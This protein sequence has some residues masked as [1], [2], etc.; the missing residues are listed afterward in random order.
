ML[1]RDDAVNKP[2][3]V[4]ALSL[5]NGV[6]A[7]WHGK[8][9]IITSPILDAETLL[10]IVIG[11]QAV[12]TSDDALQ[13]L[14]ASIGA[15]NNG[16]GVW[17]LMSLAERIECVSAAMNKILKGDKRSELITCLQ[18]EICKNAADAAAEVDRT[19]QFVQDVIEKLRCSSQN[20]DGDGGG[21]GDDEEGRSS[22]G[23][24]DVAGTRYKTFRSPVG[25]VL[26]LGP[27]NYPLNET[28]TALIPALLLGNVCVLKV[29]ALG[30]LV[31]AL[32]MEAFAD[33]LPPSTLN[34]V[35][36]RGRETLGP[37]MSSGSVD[38]LAFIG[39]ST[40]A[41]TLIKQ[42]PYP[43]R[44]KL[45]LQLEGKNA[46][47]ILPD[48]DLDLA[49]EQCCLG[50]LSFN[51]QRCTAI[52]LIL[53]HSSVENAF[54]AKLADRIKALR[55]GLPFEQGVA[56]TPLPEHTRAAFLHELVEDAL[57]KGARKV[58]TSPGGGGG[59]GG[60]EGE[61]GGGTNMGNIFPPVLLSHV[62]LSSSLRVVEEEQFGPVVPVASFLSDEQVIEFLSTQRFGQQCSIFT[63]SPSSSS[64]S[65][66]PSSSSSSSSS[67]KSGNGTIENTSTTSLPL[68]LDVLAKCVGRINFNTQC[69]R[70][71]DVVPFSGRK[72]SALGR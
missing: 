12:M 40:A 36:G 32:T 66:S 2:P 57:A 33:C 21:G 54:V 6:C 39:S 22:G 8:T 46:A 67:N 29:P 31:H 58:D 7:P 34:F 52:K 25:L 1:R 71:P 23:W 47:I 50:A 3:F 42:H 68:L 15:W 60:A 10:P 53:V 70:G 61:K 30:G 9:R 41:D 55:V 63:S 37:L 72:D 4:P 17:P 51:G 26:C 69:S 14:D 62:S 56:I 20:S 38:L 28:Y 59:G 24:H 13:I 48:A 49:A 45:F 65:S 35:S 44:L 5:I 16:R 19:Y 18:W 27:F 11:E 64:S 43:H